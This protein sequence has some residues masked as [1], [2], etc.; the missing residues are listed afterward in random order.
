MSKGYLAFINI[1]ESSWYH[2]FI[3]IVE[4]ELLS[5]LKN[6]LRTFIIT[7]DF[8]I[9]CILK[10]NTV[11]RIFHNISCYEPTIFY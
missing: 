4:T 7:T 2:A 5:E 9:K 6:V 11:F 10:P 8:F 1:D 3:I